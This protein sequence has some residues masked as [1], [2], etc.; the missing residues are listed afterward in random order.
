MNYTLDELKY[1]YAIITGAPGS[2]KSTTIGFI[3]EFIPK[4]VE[5]SIV[6]LPKLFVRDY[7]NF[8][9]YDKDLVR[10]LIYDLK[11]RLE[12]FDNIC[13]KA[14]IEDINYY[15]STGEFPVVNIRT[16]ND[17]NRVYER[18]KNEYNK[19]GCLIIV[20]DK[21][22]EGKCLKDPSTPDDLEACGAENYNLPIKTFYILNDSTLIQLNKA[23]EKFVINLTKN[24]MATIESPNNENKRLEE[25]EKK[26]DSILKL[27][28]N[29]YKQGE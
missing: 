4:T 21:T 20:R 29:K 1:D 7:V 26:V 8:E 5:L 11:T 27:I 28:E 17:I 24:N 13:T 12:E 22:A 14:I 16:K 9:Y 25:L 10:K 23:V 18:M 3:K 19:I 15:T 6:D 2:G